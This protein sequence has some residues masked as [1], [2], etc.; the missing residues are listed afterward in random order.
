MNVSDP[1]QPLTRREKEVLACIG[2]GMTSQETADH[3]HRSIKT[4]EAHRASITK[5]LHVLIP[6]I[7]RVRIA[8]WVRDNPQAVQP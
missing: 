6:N 1:T 7:N 5:K 3:I 2:Q 4:V 8:L